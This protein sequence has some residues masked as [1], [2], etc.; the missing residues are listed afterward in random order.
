MKK[1]LPIILLL[2]ANSLYSQTVSMRITQT[3]YSSVDPD[4]VGPATGSVTIQFELM[5]SS[6][7]VL[8]DGMGLSF[9]YQSAML[10]PTPTNTTTAQGPLLTSSGWAQGVDNR[11]GTTVSV[12]YGSQTF[13]RRMIITFQQ[14]EGVP[15]A[16]ITN[17]WTPVGQVTYWTLG[18]AKPEGGYATPEPGSIIPQN[19]LSSD[20]GLTSYDFLCPDL[21]TPLALGS[22]VTP[23]SFSGFDARCTNNGTVI[24]W[25]TASEFN[26]DYFD[27]ER[28]ANGNDWTQVGRVKA[29]GTTSAAHDYRLSDLSGGNAFY[30]IKQVDLDGHVTYTSI[31]RT[32]CQVNNMAM[33]IY[34][35]PAH[36]M[37]NVVI[38][39]DKSLK[40]KLMVIDGVGRVVRGMDV[41]LFKGNNKFQFDLKGLSSGEYLIRCS[42]PG[43]D[44]NRK[45]SIAR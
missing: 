31:I 11:T 12:T 43:I 17:T 25:S 33:V 45:F 28:S 39:S 30:R 35:V 23:V 1:I 4:G 34:P 27:L 8:G 26:S 41:N 21:N 32:N 36:N 2:L 18:T 40:T 38:S 9:V 19:S 24:N 44:L 10:M 22:S 37:L 15:N 14:N 29:A 20:G 3:N 7:T 42:D 13:D 5:T 16:P 6:G